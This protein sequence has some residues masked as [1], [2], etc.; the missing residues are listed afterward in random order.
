VCKRHPKEGQ[1][2]HRGRLLL[3]SGSSYSM[4]RFLPFCR[5]PLLS[6]ED[7]LRVRSFL[8]KAPIGSYSYTG[9]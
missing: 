5:T 2:S 4:A 9:L 8:G 7:L 1:R 3:S 6:S